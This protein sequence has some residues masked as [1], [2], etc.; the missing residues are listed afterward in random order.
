MENAS[1]YFFRKKQEGGI[2]QELYVPVDDELA[3]FNDYHAGTDISNASAEIQAVAKA[4]G[5]FINRVNKEYITDYE[6]EIFI[7]EDQCLDQDG[8]EIS[9]WWETF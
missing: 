1:S 5:Y 3:R 2:P 6:T 9:T 8:N 7:N 4:A